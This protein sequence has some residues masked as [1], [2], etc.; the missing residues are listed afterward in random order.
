M[1]NLTPKQR[2]LDILSFKRVDRIPIIDFGYWDET[3]TLWH[4]QGLPQNIDTEEKVE[5]YFGLDRG[6]EANLIN[7]WDGNDQVGFL[8]GIFPEFERKV[9]EETDTTITYAGE[10]G[11]TIEHKE[12]GSIPHHVKLP[13][14]NMDDF[15]NK[16]VPRMN[17]KDKGRLTDKFFE[18]IQYNIENEQPTGVW[19][20]GFLGWPRILIGIENLSY[21]YYDQ[22]ELIHAINSQHVQFVKDYI[23]IALGYTSI[24]YA[25]FFED[26]AYKNGSLVSPKIFDEFMKPYY[27]DLISYLRK[28]GVSKMMVD[29]DGNTVDLCTKFIEVG[30]DAHYPCE[31]QAGSDPVVLRKKYPNL[32]LIGGL[33]KFALSLG[34][35]EIDKELSKI[36][37]LIEQGGYIPALD[38]R[39][40]PNVP[41]YN[42]QYYIDQKRKIIEKYSK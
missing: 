8:W 23:D 6:F 29:S 38:H 18:M 7:Y 34:K 19:I 40:P 12:S 9:I 17:A 14:E 41:L 36:P 10:G 31:V 28:K 39:V 30:I 1:S 20:D 5:N 15:K 11:I 35:D 2:F 24:D 13:V 37:A 27:N 16:I 25:C 3:I 26:M 4:T 21:F 32:A 22:P 33:E 42:Y